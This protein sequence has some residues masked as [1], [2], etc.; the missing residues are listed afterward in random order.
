MVVDYLGS[1]YVPHAQLL[2][3]PASITCNQL[4]IQLQP[5]A[6]YERY[7]NI[8]PLSCKYA[9]R[10]IEIFGIWGIPHRCWNLLKTRRPA[11]ALH[12]HLTFQRAGSVLPRLA[13]ASLHPHGSSSCSLTF[14]AVQRAATWLRNWGFPYQIPQVP[15]HWKACPAHL[16]PAPPHPSSVCPSLCP[17]MFLFPILR[18][19]WPHH[20]LFLWN[21]SITRMPRL[22]LPQR[23]CSWRS[24]N[25]LATLCKIASLDK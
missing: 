11:S 9:E 15:A 5:R 16:A 3:I 1:S 21:R 6:V 2:L 22:H 13:L 18:F 8:M 4:K 14:S 10:Y 25:L 7:L 20:F 17:A 12:F 19:R 23:S 24:V